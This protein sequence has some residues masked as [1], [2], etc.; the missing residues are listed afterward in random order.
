MLSKIVIE[1]FKGIGER[2]ELDF[3]PITLL[4]GRN[5]SGK[6]TIIHAI[7]YALEVLEHRNLDPGPIQRLAGAIDFHGFRNIVHKK[8]TSKAI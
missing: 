4:F 5:S 2:V 1:N 7:Y 3:A 8:D 6:S